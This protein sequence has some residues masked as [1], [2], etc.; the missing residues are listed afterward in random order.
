MW[1]EGEFEYSESFSLLKTGLQHHLQLHYSLSKYVCIFNIKK[2]GGKK[3]P[4][5]C[6]LI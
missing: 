6:G 3:K 5:G 2:K 1:K 4:A